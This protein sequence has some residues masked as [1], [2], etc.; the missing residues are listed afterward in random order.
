MNLPKIDDFIDSPNSLLLSLIGRLTPW[1]AL[2]ELESLIDKL[3]L[4]LDS[5]E[6]LINNK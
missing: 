4:G 5:Q 1:Q 2:S 6:Y 3:L